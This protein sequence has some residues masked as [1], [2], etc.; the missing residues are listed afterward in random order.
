[1]VPSTKECRTRCTMAKLAVFSISPSVLVEL[2][3]TNKSSMRV[4]CFRHAH[5]VM[6]LRHFS[7]LLENH[8]F[9][10]FQGKVNKRHGTIPVFVIQKNLNSLLLLLNTSNTEFCLLMTMTIC[11]LTKDTNACHFL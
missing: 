7:N 4:F 2:L 5:L 8:C 3:S 1:M 9:Q 11:A 10:H 6:L